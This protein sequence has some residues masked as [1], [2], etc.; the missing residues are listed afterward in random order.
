MAPRTTGPAPSVRPLVEQL[1][2]SALASKTVTREQLRAL[3][4]K[5]LPTMYGAKLGQ[6][7]KDAS[8]TVCREARAAVLK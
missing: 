3:P 5:S 4:D 6:G 1:M 7:G 8:A 2:R